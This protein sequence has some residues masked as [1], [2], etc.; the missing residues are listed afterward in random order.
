MDP[1]R[2]M[3]TPPDVDEI[4]LKD[5][6]RP[7]LTGSN[8]TYIYRI[9]LDVEIQA[10]DWD[11]LERATLGSNRADVLRIVVGNIPEARRSPE[12]MSLLSAVSN[13]RSGK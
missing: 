2:M 13:M 11:M 9:H 12:V 8:P 10:D 5:Y 6:R 3:G 1:I 4:L 7:G